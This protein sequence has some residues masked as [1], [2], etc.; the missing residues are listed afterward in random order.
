[1]ALTLPVAD[2]SAPDSKWSGPIAATRA[3]LPKPLSAWQ[4]SAQ[5]KDATI[6]LKLTPPPR[7]SDPG[8]LHFFAHAS[9]R[10]EPSKPPLLARDGGDY[11][12]TLPVSS[13]LA[14]DFKRIDGVITVSN[15][16]A[17]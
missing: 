9:S 10:I 3:A 14:G 13:E 6:A 2:T 8:A 15:G 11:V 17:D 1:L 12:L 5:G 16:L 4:A 7:A